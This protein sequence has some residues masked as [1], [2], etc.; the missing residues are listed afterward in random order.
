MSGSAP[1]AKGVRWEQALVAV[2]RARWPLV[3]RAGAGT[4]QRSGDLIAGPPDWVIEAKSHTDV[5]RALR[6]GVDQ[7]CDTAARQG[8]DRHPVLLLKRPRRTEPLDGYAVMR[9]GDW[10]RIVTDDATAATTAQAGEG[11]PDGYLRAR[12]ALQSTEPAEVLVRRM[13]DEGCADA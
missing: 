1:R 13:R 11:D 7:V 4:R 2:L 5:T 8:H 9:I 10:L 6:E 12:G 3:E